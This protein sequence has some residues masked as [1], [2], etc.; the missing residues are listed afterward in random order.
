MSR[1]FG[2]KFLQ[3]FTNIRSHQRWKSRVGCVE[4]VDVLPCAWAMFQ[5]LKT[6]SEGF[7]GM[8]E[9]TKVREEFFDWMSCLQNR[10]TEDDDLKAKDH[11]QPMENGITDHFG[12]MYFPTWNGKVRASYLRWPERS[13]EY[14]WIELAKI[15][16]NPCCWC[17]LVFDV[18]LQRVGW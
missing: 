13:G 9:A 12:E 18:L 8:F 15:N 2:R 16:F 4:A 14:I 11:W 10:E 17:V 3:R 7:H 1:T 6:W 5:V